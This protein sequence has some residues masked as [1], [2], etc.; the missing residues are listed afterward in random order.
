MILLGLIVL[1]YC[2]LY[3]IKKN[4]ILVLLYLEELLVYNGLS[5]HCG[6]QDNYPGF[7]IVWSH[8]NNHLAV[9]GLCWKSC[10]SINVG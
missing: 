1:I 7:Q 6:F 10:D 5:S 4:Y 8:K 3:S 9:N 2:E